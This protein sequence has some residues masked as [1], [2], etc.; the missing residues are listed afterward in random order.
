[1]SNTILIIG[2]SGSGKSTSLRNLDPKTTFIINV[3][4]KN[5][6]FRG[7]KKH[8]IH[9]TGWDDKEGNYLAT[10][11]WAK[12]VKCIHMVDKNR[13]EITTIILDDWQYIM[14]YEYMKRI[15]EKTSV[16]DKFAEIGYHG[17]APFNALK[18]VR[19]NLTGFIM[20]HNE[21]DTDGVS[22]LKTM[23]KLLKEK[24]TIE[25]IFDAILHTHVCNGEYFFQTQTD[26][27]SIARSSMGMFSDKL[28]PNDLLMVK[29]AV[30][31][32][33]NDEE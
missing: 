31:S 14:S 3:I 29:Q 30:E 22:K 1:M 4:G 28:I 25:G 18:S 27:S 24:L 12:I 16:F 5:L 17:W 7:F 8:Y 13:P 15:H 19:D 9:L 2:E 20:A 23:G 33:F 21:I 10:D 11:D 32:Y 26:E 6:P